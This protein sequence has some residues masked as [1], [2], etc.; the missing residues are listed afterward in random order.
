M[1]LF[2]V[3]APDYTDDDAINRRLAAREAHLAKAASNP[4]MST[5]LIAWLIISFSYDVSW[6]YAEIGG[7]ML[8]PNEALDTPEAA[9]KMV[10]SFMIWDCESYTAAV[11]MLEDDP[12]W[13]GNVVWRY[14]QS[15]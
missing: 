11:K 2:A 5:W 14:L 9:R 7:A 3:Y 4:S 10:G 8:S 12:Y 1:P 6:K 13:A 15:I